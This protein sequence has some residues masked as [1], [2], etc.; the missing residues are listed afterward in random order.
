MAENQKNQNEDQDRNQQQGGPGNQGQQGDRERTQGRNREVTVRV[1][2]VV[3]K[4]SKE[5]KSRVAS[6]ARDG[7]PEPL[8]VFRGAGESHSPIQI[9]GNGL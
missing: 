9:R 1:A 7:R 8:A 4:A 3:V 6:L 5:V 2:R